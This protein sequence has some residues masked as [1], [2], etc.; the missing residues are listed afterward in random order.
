MDSCIDILVA[1]KR[2]AE[3]AIFAR[4]YA[5]SR[6]P[7]LLPKWSAMLKEQNFPFQP[8]DITQMQAESVRSEMAKELELRRQLYEQPKEAA[9]KIA[10][11][12]Q[13]FD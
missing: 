1:A 8:D 13:M 10:Q 3:A 6:L 5:P 4:A 9:S 2:M 11:V 7:E 12:K